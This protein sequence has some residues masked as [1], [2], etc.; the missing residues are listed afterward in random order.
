MLERKYL[1]LAMRTIFKASDKRNK[2]KPL[3]IS[4]TT[5]NINKEEIPEV[6]LNNEKFTHLIAGIDISDYEEGGI[7]EMGKPE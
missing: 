4:L 1:L 3:K 5:H 2:Q 7:I 6:H